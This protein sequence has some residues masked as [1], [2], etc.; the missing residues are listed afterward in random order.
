[1]RSARWRPSTSRV[2]RRPSGLPALNAELSDDVS[3]IAAAAATGGLPRPLLGTSSQLPLPDPPAALVVAVRGRAGVV[4][5]AP[6]RR[7][8]AGGVRRG[9]PRRAR[10]PRLHAH[11]DAA[12]RLRPERR[13]RGLGAARRPPGVRDHGGLVPRAHGRG[14]RRDDAGA[15]PGGTGTAA[16]RAPAR[17]GR[18][19]CPAVGLYLVSVRY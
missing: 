6:A 18:H 1:M 13:A 15:E 14:P 17:G 5:P 11:R 10:L 8:A 12:R 4:E 3:V 16:R 9:A 19:H 7:G 2:G